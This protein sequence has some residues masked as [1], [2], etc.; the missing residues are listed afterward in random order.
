MAR[1]PEG[2]MPLSIWEKEDKKGNYEPPG[3]CPESKFTVAAHLCGEPLAYLS[4]G[5]TM[6]TP[7][8]RFGATKVNAYLALSMT[9]C[10]CQLQML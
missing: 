8:L 1:L 9:I 6:I 3:V 5:Q 10:H 4:V 2:T 7:M